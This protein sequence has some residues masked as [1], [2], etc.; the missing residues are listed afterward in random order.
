[1]AFIDTLG[2]IAAPIVPG[3]MM[4]S[5][6]HPEKAYEKAGEQMQKYYRD[7]QGKLQP[8]N[9]HGL[10]QYGRLND[11]ANQ[12]N[13]PAALQAKWASTYE[14]SPSARMAQEHASQSGMNAASSMGLMGSS[15]A[16]NNIQQSA[17]EIMQ[18]DRQAYMNDLMQ[19]YMASIGIGQNIYGTGANAAGAMSNNAMNMGTNMAGAAFGQQNAPGAMLGDWLG[20]AADAGIN[21]ASGGVKKAA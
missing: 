3:N 10:D 17:G 6:L 19:K 21:F 7:A 8:Y 5:F 16:L 20:K 11:Q 9:Q 2:K 12:L 14:M 18:G 1:M 13:D 4:D 15:G